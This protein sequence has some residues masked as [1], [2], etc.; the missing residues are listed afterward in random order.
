M[1][2]KLAI[3]I[4]L[5]IFFFVTCQ[6]FAQDIPQEIQ[7]LGFTQNLL[8]SYDREGSEEFFTFSELTAIQVGETITFI[9]ENGKVKQRIKG[10]IAKFLEKSS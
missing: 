4:L 3:A 7:N 6:L 2:K 5:S 8:I 9:V 10:Q 1:H